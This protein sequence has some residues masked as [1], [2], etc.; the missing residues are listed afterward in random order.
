MLESGKI[1]SIIDSLISQALA[2]V[3][4]ALEEDRKPLTALCQKV[5][6]L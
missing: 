2:F 3:N 6:T 4:V 1:R 5:N